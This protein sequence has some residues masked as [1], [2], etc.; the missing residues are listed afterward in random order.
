MF[1]RTKIIK[2]TPLLQLVESFRNEEG[3]PRQ[4][5]IAS[6]GDAQIPPA[7]QKIIARAVEAQLSGQSDLFD[8]TL[9]TEAAVWVTRIVT[10]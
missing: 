2:S 8:A 7:D 6:L 4:R 5:V 3:L 1:F 9:S 10:V